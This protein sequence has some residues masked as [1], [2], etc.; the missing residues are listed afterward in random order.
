MSIICVY[1]CLSV[2]KFLIDF[3]MRIGQFIPVVL[4]SDV[5]TFNCTTMS[6]GCLTSFPALKDSI[7]VSSDADSIVDQF[8]YW[9]NR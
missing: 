5:E 9:F 4:V 6:D 1:L 8:M 2:V 3:R 7:M